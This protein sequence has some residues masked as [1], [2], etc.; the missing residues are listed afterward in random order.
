MSQIQ[1]LKATLH[2]VE[3]LL[4]FINNDVEWTYLLMEFYQQAENITACLRSEDKL[5]YSC[6]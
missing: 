5:Q 1:V 2:P 3:L 4:Q 6:L